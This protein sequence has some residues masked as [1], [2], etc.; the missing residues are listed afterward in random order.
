MMYE[1]IFKIFEMVSSKSSIKAFS[2]TYGMEAVIKARK[3]SRED[4]EE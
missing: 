1:R 2:Y 4:K 3:Q